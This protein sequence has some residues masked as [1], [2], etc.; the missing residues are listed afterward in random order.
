MEYRGSRNNI[1][2]SYIQIYPDWLKLGDP[3]RE[4]ADVNYLEMNIWNEGARWHFRLYNKR[5]D[6]GEEWS[7]A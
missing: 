4:G 5:V 7:E 6:L 3:E 2:A 1:R